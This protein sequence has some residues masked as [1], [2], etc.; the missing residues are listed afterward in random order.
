MRQV[1]FRPTFS[2]R[3]FISQKSHLRD[4]NFNHLT[5]GNP[6]TV[7]MLLRVIPE[8]TVPIKCLQ[9]VP[10]EALWTMPLSQDGRTA[11]RWSVQPIREEVLFRFDFCWEQSDTNSQKAS[12]NHSVERTYTLLIKA[13]RELLLDVMLP[14]EKF[15]THHTGGFEKD[16]RTP[17]APW[18]HFKATLSE[19]NLPPFR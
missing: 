8:V 4:S 17:L 16:T 18:L 7:F 14:S 6:Q 9:S 3:I 15:V 19:Q 1:C 11:L 10:S 2:P 13:A 12:F 5:S